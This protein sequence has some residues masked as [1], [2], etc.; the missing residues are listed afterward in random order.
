MMTPSGARHT[1]PMFKKNSTQR[2]LETSLVGWALMLLLLRVCKDTEAIAAACVK[3]LKGQERVLLF[4]DNLETLGDLKLFNFLDNQLPD[5]V[6]LI[7]TSRVHKLRNFMYQKEL[8]PLPARRVQSF[9]VMN[10]SNRAP[11]KLA[12]TPIG[13]LE[14]KAVQLYG[15][16]LAIRWFAW[17]CAKNPTLWHSEPSTLFHKQNIDEFCVA[18]TLRNLP[19]ASIL[20]LAAIAALQDKM[21]V[22]HQSPS[23]RHGSFGGSP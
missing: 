23:A 16:P 22:G 20:A 11:D 9:F 7:T 18:H 19:A 4:V 6:S 1:D 13:D 17:A 8:A 12:D 2:S 14:D 15:T 5:S 3:E 10:S 21:T